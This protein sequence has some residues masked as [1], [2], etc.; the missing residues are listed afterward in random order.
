MALYE[1]ICKKCNN[2]FEEIRKFSDESPI[3][4]PFCNSK[5]V[6][7]IISKSSFILKGNGW[8][9]DGYGKK[10][11]VKDDK[12]ELTEVKPSIVKK[13]KADETTKD[14]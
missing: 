7:K 12:E 5:R 14:S 11:D 13:E 8:Y 1:F 2:K 3:V 10:K 4:C 9:K 6:K